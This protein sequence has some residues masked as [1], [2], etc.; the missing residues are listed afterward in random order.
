MANRVRH[1]LFYTPREMRFLF[2]FACTLFL[3]S[4]AFPLRRP[5]VSPGTNSVF[6]CII[7]N[8]L[9]Y[10]G[11][12]TKPF[13]GDVAIN[14]DTIAAIGDL[15]SATANREV[16]ANGRAVAP[17]F[18]NMLSWADENLRRNRYSVSDIKQGVTL[19][20]LGE[21]FSPGPIRRKSKAEA[22]SL[23]TTLGE[24][25]QYLERKGFTPN[26]ASFVGSTSVRI[27]EMDFIAN[28]PTPRQINA[29]KNLVRQAMEEGAMG[30]STS[31]IYPP[32][33]YSS[34]EEI[35]ELAKVASEYGGMYITH[36]RSEGD[37][38]LS[39]IDETIRISKEANIPTE[40]YHLKINLQRNW[41]KI[42]SVIAKIDSARSAGVQLTA[43][44]YPYIASGTGLTARLPAWVQEGG[45]VEMRKR[46]R[47]P[48]VRKKVLFE[49]ANGIPSKN[50]DPENVM[51]MHF[52][53]DELNRIYRGKT[54]A[55]AA[56]IYGKDA[57]QTAIDLIVRDKSRIESLFFQQS[58]DVVRRIMQL[59]YV[60]FGSD[61]GS[62]SLDDGEQ[63]LADHPRAFGTFARVLAKYVRDERVLTLEEAIRKMTA[64]PASN[65][66]IEKR[67]QLRIGHF[68]DLV[69]FH[70]DS[71]ADLATYENP[72]QY[73]KGV[74]HVFVNGVQVLENG[75]HTYATPGRILRGPGWVGNSVR[76][77]RN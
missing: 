69:I 47:S 7:R 61:G 67:G 65:L 20:V 8:A 27:Y 23:W 53:L 26:V 73:S 41:G 2:S 5:V 29:M 58:E 25:F 56:R 18:I 62:Y 13:A 50:S 32:A 49:M 28:T 1:S 43:N 31:L 71:V 45:A 15:K 63:Y 10:D 38:I 22:D 72:H 42:D 66:K 48:A 30:L 46:L 4:L 14:A 44:M 17:G 55:E 59:P 16:D 52:R 3:L 70:P 60:S 57:D 12:G 34:T 37:R 75:E 40:I 24:Y 54:L 74:D 36:M 39:A 64:L 77:L 33:V 51:L 21:G 6:D 76:P 19:E 68:A 35:I 11:T 9:I